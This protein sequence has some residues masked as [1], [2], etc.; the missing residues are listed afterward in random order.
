[1][2]RAAPR[3]VQFAVQTMDVAPTD[4]VLE[5]GCGRGVATELVARHLDRGRIV[6]IDRSTAMVNLAARRSAAHVA[7]G[8]AEFR[9]ADLT[10]ALQPRERFSKIFSINVNVFWLPASVSIVAGQLT[11]KGRL[12]V[13]HEVPGADR[14][15]QIGA[16][17]VGTLEAQGLLASLSFEPGP[18]TLLCVQAY[19]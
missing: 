7:A 15:R 10:V 12:Y 17:V 14:A 6:A 1:M 3:R 19:R 5:V 8:R 2:T 13:F 16:R 9:A 4:R 11:A 18:T